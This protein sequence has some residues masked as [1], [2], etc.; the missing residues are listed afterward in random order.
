MTVEPEQEHG[1]DCPPKV[2][3]AQIGSLRSMTSFESPQRKPSSFKILLMGSTFAKVAAK[4]TLKNNYDF[5]LLI[6]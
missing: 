1:L 2:R 4:R 6:A 5:F 3:E